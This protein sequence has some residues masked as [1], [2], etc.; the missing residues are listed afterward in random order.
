MLESGRLMELLAYWSWLLAVFSIAVMIAVS[1]HVVLSKRDVH[2]AL[3]WI[4]IIWMTPLIG[5]F[6]YLVFGINRIKRRARR[7]RRRPRKPRA[8]AN[9]RGD[10]PEPLLPALPPE[11]A[12]LTSLAEL[13]E[14]VTE[15]RLR[16]GNLVQPLYDGDQAYPAMLKAIH[17]AEHSVGILMYIFNNDATGQ[18]FVDALARA[19]AR[20]V[21]VRVLVD[22]VGAHTIWSSIVNPLTRAN[23]PAARF[24]PKWIPGSFAYANLRNHR[25]IMVVDG[26]IAFTGGMNIT[27]ESWLEHKPKHPVHDVQFRLEGPIVEQIQ[28]VFVEDWKFAAG[29]SLQGDA[30]F[31]KLE[32]RGNILARGVSSGPDEDLEKIRLV[33]LGALASARSSVRIITPYFLPDPGM[34]SALNIASLRGV[35]VDILIPK[36]GD[37]R[38]VQWACTAQLPQVIDHGCRVWLTS[39][40]FWHTKLM[41]V[42]GVWTF[43]GSANWDPRSLRLNFE[44][45]VECYDRALAAELEKMIQRDIAQ[46]ERLT[47]GKWNQRPFLI[48][49]RDATARL[50][51]PLL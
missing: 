38:L 35:E 4:A 41:L 22:D 28:S 39:P 10:L 49:L 18:L 47:I 3:A 24:L 32:S 19:V 27:E 9:L 43:L 17:E 14:T 34:I 20:K 40:P 8:P 11:A 2:A 16:A 25:K 31:P 50:L 7:L 5:G 15:K 23:V 30:W 12:H 29:E 37:L 46:S 51:S 36:H 13:A 33:I 44:F 42:D 45:N 26:K 1:V 48:R 6:M 21:E